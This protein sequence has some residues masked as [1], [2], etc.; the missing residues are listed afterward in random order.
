MKSLRNLLTNRSFLF[1]IA[2]YVA[3]LLVLSRRPEFSLS[4]TLSELAIF[5]F[6][7]PLLAWLTTRRA[8]RLAVDVDPT[9]T[10]MLVLAGYVLALSLYLAFGPQAIDSWLPR[11]WIESER[12]EFFVTLIKKLLVFVVLPLAIFGGGF[13][14]SLRN[15]GFQSAGLRELFRSHLPLIVVSCVA[16]LTFQYFLGG[17]AAPLREGK[18]ST[19]ELLLGLPLCLLWLI[20][21]TG[22]V[23]EF[24]F[25]ALLQ[26]R[27]SVWFRSEITGVVLMALVFGLA[28]APGF[29][30]RHAGVVEGLGANP[31]PLDAIA[32]SIVTLSVAGIFAG[33]VWT[34]TRNLFALML[35]HAA[36]DLFPNLSDFVRVWL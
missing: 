14:C 32:Y 7:F 18:F 29:I 17:A 16:I 23:E 33:V 1:A 12:I 31:S 8:E 6:A 5:G 15:F 30:F 25:R 9:G 11:N 10:E 36:T 4:E 21:E 13:R 34:R 22:L 28:H 24:F 20:I 3:A 19:N 2:L 35:L 27:L 26:T